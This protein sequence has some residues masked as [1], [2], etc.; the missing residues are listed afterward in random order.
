MQLKL[1]KISE[2]YGD[3]AVTHCMCQKWFVKFLGITDI[4]AK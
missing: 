4:L 2:V 1:K 3:G